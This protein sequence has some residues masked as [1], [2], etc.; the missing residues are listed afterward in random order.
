MS[1]GIVSAQD[2]PNLPVILKGTVNIDGSPA[3]AG[4]TITAKVGGNA[5]GA[6]SVLTAGS[7]GDTANGRLPVSASSNGAVD[8]YVNGIK[9]TPSPAFTYNSNDAG[10]TSVVNLNAPSSTG[11][12]T[13]TSTPTGNGGTGTGGNGRTSDASSGTSGTSTGGLGTTSDKKTP[14]PT[15]KQGEGLTNAPGAPE[16]KDTTVTDGTTTKAVSPPFEFSSILG[17]FV[18]VVIGAIIIVVLKRTGK[19]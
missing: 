13:P 7:Y 18:V 16:A 1:A 5:A 4:T 3:P 17:M 9:A 10:N 8:F 12:A 19:I 2:P 6:T 15:P 14:I 11:T